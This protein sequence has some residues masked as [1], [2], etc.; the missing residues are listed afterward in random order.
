MLL[1]SRLVAGQA[2]RFGKEVV[3]L[4]ER[5]QL[6]LVAVGAAGEDAIG[7]VWHD[8]RLPLHDARA[9]GPPAGIVRIYGVAEQTLVRTVPQVR[10]WESKL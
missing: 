5:V 1:N 9:E 6:L 7:W 8:T 2:R 10:L 4:G 3:V